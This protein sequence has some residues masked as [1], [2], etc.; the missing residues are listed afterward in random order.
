LL[1]ISADQQQLAIRPD[2]N[3]SVCDTFIKVAQ[4]LTQSGYGLLDPIDQLAKLINFHP[5]FAPYVNITLFIN[6]V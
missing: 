1:N 2:Y 3:A 6:W 4:T 5:I